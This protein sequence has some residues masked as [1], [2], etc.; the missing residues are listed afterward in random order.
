MLIS[1]L[2][3]N[4]L[5]VVSKNLAANIAALRQKRSLTQDALAKI[6]EIPRST[7]THLESG[8][9]N[10]ELRNL[11][12]VAAAL[13]ITVE[14]LLAKPRASCT[15]TKAADMLPSKRSRGA[16]LLFNLLPDPIPGLQ[17]ERLEIEVGS[18]MIGIPH[19]AGT[20]EYL[21]CLQSEVTVSVAGEKYQVQKHDTLAFPGDQRHSYQNTGHEKAIC[22]SVIAMVPTGV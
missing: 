4:V 20:K 5:E 10:P 19:S 9:G 12:K 14:E 22:I 7:L 8:D 13:Q 6:A 15:L 2:M 18:T 3:D 21:T 11:V 1:C 17:I 16:A